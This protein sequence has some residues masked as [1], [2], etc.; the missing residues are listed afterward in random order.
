MNL[1][2]NKV[3]VL[4]CKEYNIG[5]IKEKLKQGLKPWGGIEAFVKPGQKVLLKTNLL[6]AKSPDEAV[7]THPALVQAVVELVQEVTGQITI[8]DSPGGPFNQGRLKKIY[9]KTGMEEVADKSGVELNWNF[10]S[11]NLSF[12]N[13]KFLKNVRVGE[14][15]TDADVIINLPKFKS[16][17]LTKMTGGVKNMFGAIPGLLKAEY[18]FNMQEIDDFA[19][20]LL[21]IFMVTDPDLTIMDGIIGMEGEGPSGGEPIELGKLLI[22]SN[23]PALDVVMAELAG[24]EPES[25]PTI[26]AAKDRGLIY[27]LEE[28]EILGIEIKSEGFTVPTIDQSAQLLERRLPKPLARFLRA[29]LRPRPIFN[30]DICIQC[31]ACIRS[32]PSQVIKKTK[33][34]VEV[35]LDGCI[36]CFCCQELCPEEAVE[37]HRPWLGRILF[38]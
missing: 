15:I 18:H 34:G 33:T 13:G 4:E 32:C 9:R 3:M 35:D 36:R 14:F 31:G 25:I 21:D 26:V 30:D 23:P 11:T 6:M 38:R 12:P 2:D 8:G 22:S 20:A 24:V 27:Q 17:G 1:E 16:H 37:I 7:T 28:I 5:L 10:E 29:R 19:N